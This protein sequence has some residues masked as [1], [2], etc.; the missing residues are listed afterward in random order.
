MNIAGFDVSAK[1]CRLS[2]GNVLPMK[3]SPYEALTPT[4][5]GID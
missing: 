5:R 4:Y 3:T 2:A 1:E